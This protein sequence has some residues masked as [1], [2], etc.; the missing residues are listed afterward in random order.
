ML[1]GVGLRFNLLRDE[2]LGRMSDQRS[3]EDR[4]L[5]VGLQTTEAFG[6]FHHAGGRPAKCHRGVLPPL[7]VAT[8]CVS[9]WI[10][11]NGQ[12][13]RESVLDIGCARLV[14][15]TRVSSRTMPGGILSSRLPTV[16]VSPKKYQMPSQAMHQ[17]ALLDHTDRPPLATWRRRLKSFRATRQPQRNAPDRRPFARFGKRPMV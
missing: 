12:S 15:P 3:P 17:R 8:D 6:C 9:I 11:K 5:L 16:P 1:C 13:R 14:S 4:E 10:S 7:H 2:L